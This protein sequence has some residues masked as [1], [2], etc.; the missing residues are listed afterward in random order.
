MGSHRRARSQ[1]TNDGRFLIAVDAGSNQLSVLRINFRWQSATGA[2]WS[3]LF[4]WYDAG[5]RRGA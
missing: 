5:Q 2:Q 4:G 3:G 1:V